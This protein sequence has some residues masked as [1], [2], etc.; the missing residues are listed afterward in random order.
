MDSI[1][2]II[3]HKGNQEYVHY[4][5]KQLKKY[6]NNVILLNDNP[7]NFNELKN[8]TC[9]I[10]NYNNYSSNV[11]KFI[12]YYKHFSHNDYHFELICI[13]RW[14][15]IYEYMKSNNIERAFICDSDILIYENITSINDKY[16]KDYDFMLCTSSSKNVAGSQSIWNFQKLEEFIKF[17]FK[18]YTIE[19]L[20]KIE[21]WWKNYK[22]PGGICDMTLLYYFAN[23]TLD[24][25]GLRLPN[26]PYFNKDL[27][28]IFNNEITFDNH[29]ATYGN[30]I[31]P[32]DYEVNKSNNNKN[33]LFIDKKPYSYNKRLK[34]NI[35]F[36]SIHFQ[37]HNKKIMKEYFNKS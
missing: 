2:I 21:N 31:N 19:N 34:K 37:G 11:E 3:F 26:F 15:Y 13:I 17:I 5:L 28:Q 18:F 4:C 32:E 22:Q 33:I 36:V 16:L 1:P 27:T 29:L 7:N 24:F 8:T 6:D 25:V 12:S 23:N 20:N 14:I 10:V 35:G 9:N 30:H